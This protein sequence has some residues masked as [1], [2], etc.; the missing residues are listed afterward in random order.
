[1]IQISATIMSWLALKK[2][3]NHSPLTLFPLFLFLC[4]GSKQSH[5]FCYDEVFINLLI[6]FTVHVFNLTIDVIN[7]Q[8]LGK[9]VRWRTNI[10][11]FS[12]FF[13]WVFSE[14]YRSQGWSLFLYRSFSCRGLHIRSAKEENQFN[15]FPLTSPH[16]AL[17][18][19]NA[20]CW[21][22][23]LK[24]CIKVYKRLCRIIIIMPLEINIFPWQAGLHQVFFY[25]GINDLFLSII[26][27]FS[28]P[29]L[30]K[31]DCIFMPYKHIKY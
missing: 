9:W 23:L 4:W 29:W 30:P 20:V 25:F 31:N 18:V 8:P 21:T 22:I 17:D 27:I 11:K 24:F 14:V 2:E 10:F 15:T 16:N 1:M 28:S 12:G 19:Q 6:L 7:E 26:L 5:F 3:P 13:L